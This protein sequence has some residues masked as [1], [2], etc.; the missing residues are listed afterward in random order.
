MVQSLPFIVLSMNLSLEITC[1]HWINADLEFC[2]W[3]SNG[4]G[5]VFLDSN[6]FL[7]EF[8]YRSVGLQWVSVNLGIFTVF[9][10]FLG[11]QNLLNRT[12]LNLY[13]STR[14]QIHWCSWVWRGKFFWFSPGFIRRFELESSEVLESDSVLLIL[15]WNPEI[16]RWLFFFF[17]VGSKP[18]N[19]FP[20]SSQTSSLWSH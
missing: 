13:R 9:K 10:D 17:F 1:T 18:L 3:I 14:I 16:N 7:N 4:F 15:A 11:F 5:L 8:V 6:L 12:C 2:S 20:F 19:F